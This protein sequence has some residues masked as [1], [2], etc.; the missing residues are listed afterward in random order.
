VTVSCS[1]PAVKSAVPVSTTNTS[2]YGWTC[3]SGRVHAG[4]R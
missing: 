3:R 1:S 2:G 4:T